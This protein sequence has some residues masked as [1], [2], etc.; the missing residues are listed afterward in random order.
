[1][2][3]DKLDRIVQARLKLMA[4]FKDKISSSPSV[5]DAKPLGEG[6]PNRHGMPKLP[7]GQHETEG[8]P[9]LDLGV[10]PDVRLDQW[11]LSVDGAVEEPITLR[12]DDF[13][14][15]E[16]VEDVSDFHCVTTW[17]RMDLTWRGV[18]ASTVIA[19]ARPKE[20]A[21]HVMC[22]AYDGYSTNV[23][24]EEVL[25]DDVLLVHTVEGEPLPRDHG[26]PVR[27]IT[28]Q[29]YAWKGAKWIKRLELMT[30][31]KHGFWEERGYSDTALPW[32][33]DRYG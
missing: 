1:L 33:N 15:L 23:A 16:Q 17:S 7:V 6:E 3:N 27:M 10:H 25:K 9:V 5:A 11:T 24:L 32:R 8:W 20:S 19:L 18:R 29:L 4:R 14:A 31:D 2:T 21:T 28:P 12:W 30:K 22:W 26:G 13:M